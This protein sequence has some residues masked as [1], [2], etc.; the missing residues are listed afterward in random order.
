VRA[1][2]PEARVG[3]RVAHGGRRPETGTVRSDE[4]ARAIRGAG[5]AGTDVVGGIVV[6]AAVE[7]GMVDGSAERPVGS[8]V[9]VRSAR[10]AELVAQRAA[11][12]G[13]EG[14]GKAQARHDGR[15]PDG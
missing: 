7:R 9:A 3:T 8:S 11:T 1:G 14:Q 13:T 6:S 4:A 12:P 15:D 2:Q 10:E 5:R